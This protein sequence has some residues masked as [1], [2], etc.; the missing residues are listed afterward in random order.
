MTRAART[1]A[2][3]VLAVGAL[4]LAV[5]EVLPGE[6]L[7]DAHATDVFLQICIDF[8]DAK[9]HLA[10]PLPRLSAENARNQTLS[11]RR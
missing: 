3:R 2:S 7:G 1:D 8:A 5:I 4:K 9:P 11:A 10:K 6:G